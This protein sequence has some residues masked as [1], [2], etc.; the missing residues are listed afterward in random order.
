MRL[1]LITVGEPKLPYARAGWDEYAGRLSRYHK[2]RVT[3]VPNTTPEREGQ[4]IVRA[5]GNATL[6]AVD[7]RGAQ[8]TSE[9]LS[10]FIDELGVRG[11]G[12]LAFCIGGPDGLT[13]EVRAH[14][15]TLLGLSKLTFPHDLAMVVLLE[16]LYRAATISKGEPYHR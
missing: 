16:A 7:P 4:A 12:E 13:D 1:H 10:A 14:A 6:I 9:A 3:R 15:H 11:H 5:V 8:R 2:V